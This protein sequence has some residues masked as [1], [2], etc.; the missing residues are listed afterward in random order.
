MEGGKYTYLHFHRVVW[1]LCRLWTLAV[2]VM[3]DYSLVGSW[4]LQTW[5]PFLGLLPPQSFSLSQNNNW[6]M[7]TAA[8][9]VEFE[10]IHGVPL[11]LHSCARLG[12]VTKFQCNPGLAVFIS[13]PLGEYSFGISCE[14]AVT[15]NNKLIGVP[16]GHKNCKTSACRCRAEHAAIY[17]YH[18][19]QS[20]EEKIRSLLYREQR[21]MT[22]ISSLKELQYSA[23]IHADV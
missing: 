15:D 22:G 19:P 13:Y 18:W 14:S 7:Y 21:E 10:C 17:L 16:Q 5:N 2:E 23:C 1:R 12:L 11:Q 20:N 9:L 8:D 6:C 4:Q 3:R